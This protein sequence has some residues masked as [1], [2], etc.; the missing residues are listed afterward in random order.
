MR[1]DQASKVLSM[2]GNGINSKYGITS[3]RTGE[4]IRVYVGGVGV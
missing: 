3:R 1:D 2:H 4:S